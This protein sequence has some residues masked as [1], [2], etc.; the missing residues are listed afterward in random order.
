MQALASSQ[1][2]QNHN[3]IVDVL[4]EQPPKWLPPDK[5][6]EWREDRN[7]RLSRLVG[8]NS[9]W[10][11]A[12]AAKAGEI[13]QP[14]QSGKVAPDKLQE[15]RA[16]FEKQQQD[17]HWSTN[18]SPKLDNHAAQKFSEEFRPFAKRL[19]LDAAAANNLKM[20]F[21]RRVANLAAKDKAYMAQIQRYRS[22]KNPDPASVVNFAKV[23][24][25]KHSKTVME[26]LINERYKGFL[27]GKPRIAQQQTEKSGNTVKPAPGIQMVTVRPPENMIDHKRRTTTQIHDKIFPLKNGKDL[28]RRFQRGPMSFASEFAK[29]R[30]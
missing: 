26:Q 18:I 2:V 29:T 19:N 20:E 13:M 11:N 28:K 14:A 17:H 15:E 9:D 16:A 4:N 7:A 3:A 24:F 8:S 21:S 27:S 6:N 30:G 5:M 22:A 12:Q 23:E 1:L 25:N 10:L